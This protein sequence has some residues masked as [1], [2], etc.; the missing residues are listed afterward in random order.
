M[1]DTAIAVDLGG[2]NV[3]AALVGRD[4][5]IRHLVARSTRAEEGV[6]AVIDRITALVGE[7]IAYES[8]P[9]AVSV[10][11]VA[12][13]PLNPS[14]GVVYFGPNLPGWHD[15]PLRDILQRRLQR[16]VVV[17]NDGNSA[18]LGE[19]MFGAATHTR[20]LIYLALGTGVGGGIVSHGMLIEGTRGLGGEVGHIPVDPA[21]PRCTCGGIGCVE[22]YAGGW[23]IARDGEML[24]HS[25]RS[26][27]I[28]DAAGDGPITAKAVATAAHANDPAA[29][30]VFERAGRALGMGL[31]GLVNVFNP[32][33]IVIGGGLAKAGDLIMDPMREALSLYAM[34]PISE[35]VSIRPSALGQHTGIFGA[36]A[37]VFYVEDGEL[38]HAAPSG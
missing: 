7:V 15:V 28:R 26:R 23:A 24:V 34:V 12:P 10:G 36:A 31:A 6:E 3:R 38:R 13:G 4:G 18:A 25:G 17:G 14:T 22:A 32:E 21:G 30:A 16:T 19:A 29:R 2:T 1:S 20:H 37:R 27:A 8:P 9:P 11:V 35:D 33:M 5:S